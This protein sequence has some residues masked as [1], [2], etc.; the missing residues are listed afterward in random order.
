M[1]A[2]TGTTFLTTVHDGR[3]LLTAIPVPDN[4]KSV[5]TYTIEKLKQVYS[6]DV[7]ATEPRMF[8]IY[9][10]M[11]R[12]RFPP[13]CVSPH[14]HLANIS[15]SIFTP[16]KEIKIHINDPINFTYLTGFHFNLVDY[17]KQYE[18]LTRNMT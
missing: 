2:Q 8:S 16:F 18:E 4:S 10:Q 12:K 9:L 14:D 13:D 7:T 5:T 3:V 6:R 11:D 15:K 1:K 17:A